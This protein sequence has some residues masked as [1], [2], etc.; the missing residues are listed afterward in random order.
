MSKDKRPLAITC[1][2]L[3]LMFGFV[4]FPIYAFTP[5]SQETLAFVTS[6]YGIGAFV[7]RQFGGQVLGVGVA[8]LF[9]RGDYWYR[10]V[11]LKNLGPTFGY[12]ICSSHDLFSLCANDR[13]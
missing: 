8:L 7:V 1:L 2:A 12:R 6:Q 5:L 9:G 11:G 3:V 13:V 4:C 10:P